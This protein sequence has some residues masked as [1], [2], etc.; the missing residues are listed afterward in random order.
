MDFRTL[1]IRQ[2]ISAV[3]GGILGIVMAVMGAG[4]YALVAKTLV[5]GL[6]STIIL[7]RVNQ[8]HPRFRYSKAHFRDLFSFGL[9]MV[10]LRITIFFPDTLG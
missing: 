3:I 5:T 7:W 2:L 10:G 1:S 6:V 4:V 8:W 9:S